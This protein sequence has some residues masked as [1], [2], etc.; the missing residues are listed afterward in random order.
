MDIHHGDGVEEALVAE[1]GLPLAVADIELGSAQ[2][3]DDRNAGLDRGRGR[4]LQSWGEGGYP[5]SGGDR[6]G[7]SR[8]LE[9]KI[10]PVDRYAWEG[11]HRAIGPAHPDPG[12]VPFLSEAEMEPLAGLGQKA[13]AP[14]QGADQVVQTLGLGNQFH[15]GTDGIS[16][17]GGPVSA[18][19]Q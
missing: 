19:T 9:E 4:L 17:D 5:F 10:V 11:F 16:I 14:P 8:A 1:R 13:L 6:L 7:G 12:D 3:G 15:P 18:E 2:V